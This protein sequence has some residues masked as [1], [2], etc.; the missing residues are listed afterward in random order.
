MKSLKS[1]QYSEVVNFLL[2]YQLNALTYY[3]QC[4]KLIKPHMLGLKVNSVIN[5]VTPFVASFK[6]KAGA[7]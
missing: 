2:I 3:I 4:D 6:K 7:T 1:S 5:T